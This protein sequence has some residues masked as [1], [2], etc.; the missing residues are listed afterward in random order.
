VLQRQCACPVRIFDRDRC[1]MHPPC[2]RRTAAR[3][4]TATVATAPLQS[5]PVHPYP[6]STE[7]TR[8]F[9]FSSH[10]LATPLLCSF[11]ERIAS[12]TLCALPPRAEARP[13]STGRQQPKL[14]TPSASS[15]ASASPSQAHSGELP[16]QP[17]TPRSSPQRCIALR[18][19]DRLQQPPLW[20]STTAFPV[21]ERAVFF[22]IRRAPP[23]GRATPAI[24]RG[25]L[26]RHELCLRPAVL[27]DLTPSSLDR[28]I[29]YTVV[30]PL[31]RGHLNA[32]GRLRPPSALGSASPSSP[33]SPRT[34][35]TP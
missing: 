34:S 7:R 26:R 10:H 13:Q 3:R 35:S 25:C 6:F 14:S 15:V 20:P 29:A 2:P 33:S 21:A 19:P 18:P 5:R 1:R 32:D 27:A 17:P 28:L 30:V 23:L 31:R 24:L 8:S 11:D 22:V 16:V 4:P 9:P 12:S